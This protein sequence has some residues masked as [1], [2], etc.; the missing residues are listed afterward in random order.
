MPFPEPDGGFHPPLGIRTD[1]DPESMI[2]MLEFAVLDVYSGISQVLHTST[3]HGYVYDRVILAHHHKRRG[4]ALRVKGMAG[5]GKPAARAPNGKRD[6]RFSP[7]EKKSGR[8]FGR[9]LPFL[10]LGVGIV[11]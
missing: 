10:L 1:T 9:V 6:L 3:H 11:K 2:G 8:R 7:K 4:K 5:M